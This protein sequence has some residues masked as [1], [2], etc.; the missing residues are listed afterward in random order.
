MYERD[1]ARVGC[2]AVARRDGDEW[3]WSVVLGK[4]RKRN[5]PGKAVDDERSGTEISQELRVC[6]GAVWCVLEPLDE[7]SAIG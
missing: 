6:C 7:Y 1:K 2:M 3:C 5:M 4:G